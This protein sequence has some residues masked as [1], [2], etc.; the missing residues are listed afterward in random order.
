MVFYDSMDKQHF[1]SECCKEIFYH[2]TDAEHFPSFQFV[3]E[4]P[5]SLSDII[6]YIYDLK[7]NL[8]TAF[9]DADFN[10]VN[11]VYHGVNG[12][13]Y[14]HN[15]V[16]IINYPDEL[17]NQT[18]YYLRICNYN[19]PE[20]LYFANSNYGVYTFSIDDLGNLIQL[21]SD[22]QGG[23]AEDVWVKNG[24]LYLANG[25]RGIDSYSV[26]AD[27]ILTHVDNDFIAGSGKGVWGDGN[28]IYLANG[29]RG[30]ESYSADANG[31]LT[32]VDN[33]DQGGTALGV[34]GDGNFIYLANSNRGIDS[35]SVDGAG[36]LTHVDNDAQASANA[37]GVW[38]DGDFI[39]VA[40]AVRG[41]DSYSVD[42]AGA[43]T[44]ISNHDPGVGADVWGDGT[45]IYL[46]SYTGGIDSYSVDAGG[47]L[48]HLDN[49]DRDACSFGYGVWGN[50]DYI[51]LA[52]DSSGCGAPDQEGIVV[53]TVDG[54]GNFVFVNYANP[55]SSFSIGM[56]VF[57]EETDYNV[58]KCWYSEA[59]KVCDCEVEGVGDGLNLIENGWFEDWSGAAN[60]NNVP[61]GWTVVNNNATNYVADAGGEC[62]IISDNTQT[63][64]IE[65]TVLTVGSWYVATINITVVAAGSIRLQ[66]AVITHAVWNST[67]RKSVVF[68]ADAAIIRI[69]RNA[70]TDLTFTDVRVEEFVGFKFC[71]MLT[72]NW[73][74][75][76]DWDSI[77]YQ[78]GYRNSLVLNVELDSP[79]EDI[80]QNA[81]D[82]R[83]GEKFFS[84][85]VIK[86]IYRISERIP[87][88]LWNALI[89]LVAYGS[90]MPNFHAWITLPDGS[91]CSMSEVAV[92]GEWDNDNCMNTFTIEFVDNDEYPVVAGNCC[93][94][95]DVSEV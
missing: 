1:R 34:W 20:L 62:Q 50:K 14:V 89:R 3:T 32:H 94:N 48:T 81:A 11:T 16:D 53:Y 93:E 69:I 45:F 18:G 24:L 58:P 49:D 42:G 9:A 52:K 40:D 36:A 83:L 37:F 59:F 8:V 30:L 75:D 80:V 7:D 73:W 2:Y 12:Y 10:A 43:L 27:G 84:D 6:I 46:A 33:D 51:F 71:D 25:V 4:M 86:K 28:F 91:A 76:C 31:A 15:V 23:T 90:E 74:S 82:E 47:N 39:Y 54:A 66:G 57:V 44:W 95:E 78:Y 68:Q 72:L 13:Q 5:I 60:P 64:R 88:Y 55:D 87:E 22:D 26:R 65:Q 21:D 92:L 29:T 38:G 19:D 17:D 56:A 61:D 67:G 85:V 41:I 77:I 63:V 79:K 35:Y 70:V